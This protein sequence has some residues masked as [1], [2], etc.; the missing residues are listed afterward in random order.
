MALKK[1]F[2]RLFSS[3]QEEP[4]QE[5]PK[6]V[7]ETAVVM[8]EAARPP[9]VLRAEVPNGHA[10]RK[11]YERWVR[12]SGFQPPLSLELEDPGVLKDGWTT[13]TVDG[14]LA[15]HYENTILITEDGPEITT[16]TEDGAYL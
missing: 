4:A 15:A 12:Q 8:E 3:K 11:L 9:S 6:K 7:Q 16:V 1:Y 10:A 13:V 5:Q 14:S 2:S